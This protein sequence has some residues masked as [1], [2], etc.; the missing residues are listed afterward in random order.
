MKW[1]CDI[2]F[3]SYDTKEEML[4][5][6]NRHIKIDK[7]KRVYYD[8]NSKRPYA[9]DVQFEDGNVYRYVYNV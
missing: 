2:C 1:L 6:K 8:S 5:C 3:N 7:I 4:K 9:I